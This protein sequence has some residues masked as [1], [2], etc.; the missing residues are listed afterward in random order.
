MSNAYRVPRGAARSVRLY[1]LGA[2]GSET[3][4]FVVGKRRGIVGDLV[5]TASWNSSLGAFLATMT[6]AHTAART[7]G[8]HHAVAWRTDSGSEDVPVS[9]GTIEFYDVPEAA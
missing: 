3:I 9:D 4:K 6:A 7:L 2:S 1:L 8:Q 5:L